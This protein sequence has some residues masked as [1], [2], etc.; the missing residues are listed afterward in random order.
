MR[1]NRTVVASLAGAAF[2]YAFLFYYQSA[3]DLTPALA[4]SPH[5]SKYVKYY[6]NDNI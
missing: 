4:A 1:L 5:P 6:H 2:L 3:G